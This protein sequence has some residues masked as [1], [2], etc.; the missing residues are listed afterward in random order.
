MK[1]GKPFGAKGGREMDAE[2]KEAQRVSANLREWP[3]KTGLNMQE[4]YAPDGRGR[5]RASGQTA[6]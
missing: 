4:T 5:N 2:W 3:T 1:G 6:C